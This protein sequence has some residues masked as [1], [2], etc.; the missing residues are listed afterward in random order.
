MGEIRAPKKFENGV[1]SLGGRRRPLAET[2]LW[3]ALWGP[4]THMAHPRAGYTALVRGHP[5]RLLVGPRV[6]PNSNFPKTF[7]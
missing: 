5:M 6:S 7:Q 3:D 1:D 2:P 4:S